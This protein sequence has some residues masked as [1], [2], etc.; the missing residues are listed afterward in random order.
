MRT[1]LCNYGTCMYVHTRTVYVLRLPGFFVCCSPLAA[2][3]W[4][5]QLRHLAGTVMYNV[6]TLLCVFCLMLLSVCCS[7][8]LE[9]NVEGS[10]ILLEWA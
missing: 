10:Y 3:P 5:Y 7:L 1:G 6:R 2:V 4:N 9:K 8:L